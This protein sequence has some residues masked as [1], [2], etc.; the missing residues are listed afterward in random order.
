MKVDINKG[1]RIGYTTT[2]FLLLF[3]SYILTFYTA[4]KLREQSQLIR[5]YQ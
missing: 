5:L 1:M 2:A 4:N 3:F